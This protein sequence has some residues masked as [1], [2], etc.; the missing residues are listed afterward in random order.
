MN[1]SNTEG[2]QKE[3]VN[4]SSSEIYDKSFDV[5][6]SQISNVSAKLKNSYNF[7]GTGKLLL[8][9]ESI[10]IQGYIKKKSHTLIKAVLFF[11]ILYITVSI[12][13][14]LTSAS[15]DPGKWNMLTVILFGVFIWLIFSTANKVL[16][17]KKN[18]IY[19]DYSLI[20][21]IKRSNDHITFLF[22]DQTCNE[23]R[24]LSL[25]ITPQNIVDEF[26]YNL[27]QNYTIK[28]D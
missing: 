19:I 24:T 16:L 22:K 15:L 4:N 25:Y 28:F 3:L 21:T 17:N 11:P 1:I 9:K 18:S 23:E 7:S 6:F 2:D 27:K 26:I 20:S 8:K 14:F 13:G 10:E 12:A 5:I